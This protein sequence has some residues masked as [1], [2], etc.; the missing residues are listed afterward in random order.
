MKAVLIKEPGPPEGLVL[1][2]TFA[3][4]KNNAQIRIKVAAVGL[5]RADLLQRKGL[6]NPPKPIRSDILGLEYVGK[7]IEADLEGTWSIGDR[8]M[9]IAPGATY[10]EEVVVHARE[11]IRAPDHLSNEEA[12]CIP[13]AFLTAYDALFQQIKL[14]IGDRILIH[15]VGSGVGNAALQ[16]AKATG[17]YVVASSRTQ[18]KLER[19][20]KAGADELLFIHPLNK[21]AQPDFSKA[22]SAPVDHIID[23]VGASYLEQNLKSL[24]TKGSIILVGLLGGRMCDI[25]LGIILRK[26]LSII[27]TVLRMRPIEEKIALA[28]N[29]T[30]DVL[31]LFEQNKL[32]P[33]LDR[34]FKMESVVQ[35]HQYMESN[36]N[37]GKIVLTW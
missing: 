29:F 8:V 34:V 21:D 4:S 12:A 5:N 18:N 28:Q 3:P 25:N 27:G 30:H 24:K 17:A 13:E 35:A 32:K 33:A 15:A 6:Y 23:F 9:G 2:E 22:L 19:A 31:P 7:V 20:Q 14:H 1:E 36:A 16:L 11:A 26:R 37:Y 10:A